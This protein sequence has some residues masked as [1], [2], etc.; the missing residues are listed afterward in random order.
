MNDDRREKHFGRGCK[1]RPA[2]N[3]D[4]NCIKSIS[5]TVF[6]QA[7]LMLKIAQA[8]PDQGTQ[9][10]SSVIIRKNI[11]EGIMSLRTEDY[12]SEEFAGFMREMIRTELVSLSRELPKTTLEAVILQQLLDNV[13]DHGNAIIGLTEELADTR[14]E[15]NERFGQVDQRFEQ[16]DQK[17]DDLKSWVGTVVG[18]FQNRGGKNLETMTAG[19]LRLALKR[20]DI[21]PESIRLRQKIRD[22]DG[23]IGLKGRRYEV[24]IFAEGDSLLV[25]EVKSYCDLEM[26]ERFAD[27]VGL[28]RHLYPD[29][30]V[31]GALIVLEPFPELL[32][33]CR[34]NQI[35]VVS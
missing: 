6:V 7:L 19:T 27:K 20:K 16:V 15:M 9:K 17:F 28:V 5:Y 31:D 11:M 2:K 25:F 12:R 35:A 24:D 34:E 18:R 26:G 3:Y 4:S 23:I 32:N 30:R 10:G 14:K 29:K 22:T 8:I 33:F 21:D 1:P 13:K